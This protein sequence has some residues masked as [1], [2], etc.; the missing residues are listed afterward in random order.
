MSIANTEWLSEYGLLKQALLRKRKAGLPVSH[1]EV[2]YFNSAAG[3]L[4][5]KLRILSAAPQ[6]NGLAGSEIARR[7]VL[8]EN[9]KKQ[10][11]AL[12]SITAAASVD[13]GGAAGVASAGS[14]L[15][16]G[17]STEMKIGVGSSAGGF[18]SRRTGYEPV[19]TSEQGLAM[20]V[21]DM[22]GLQDDLLQDIDSSVERLHGLATGMQAEAGMHARLLDH[23]EGNIDLATVSLHAEAKRAATIKEKT[24]TFRLYC[25]L[26]LEIVILVLLL[27]TLVSG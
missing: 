17:Y 15:E 10:V 2:V 19:Q 22:V 4:D 23:M 13:T 18:G 27:L 25:C 14:D 21:M 11:V 9:L 1:D 8:L 26:V 6:S 3:S 7:Q 16:G 12:K 20:R 24:V 5:S